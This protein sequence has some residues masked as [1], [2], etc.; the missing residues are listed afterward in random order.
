VAA[1]AHLPPRDWRLLVV[2]NTQADQ[3]YTRVVRR[4]IERLQMSANIRLLGSLP[5]AQLAEALTGAHA[6]VVP[7]SYEGFGIV[8]LEGM[9]FGLPAI[10]STAGAAREVITHGED[11]LLVALDD[12]AALAE[13]LR[14][15]M[16]DRGRLARMGLAARRRYDAH[17]GWAHTAARIRDFLLSLISR[18]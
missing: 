10:A 9:A 3:P 14:V 2:G 12:S 5:E 18:A 6:L 8:Y 4:Q 13:H 17:P 7:S 16:T 15:L 1:L 11:G